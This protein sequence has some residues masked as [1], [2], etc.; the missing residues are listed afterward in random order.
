MD[1]CQ[2]LCF[3]FGEPGRGRGS[4]VATLR[5]I[6]AVSKP[7]NK[8]IPRGSYPSNVEAR[9]RWI[10]RE[11]ESWQ[12]GYDD[13]ERVPSVTAKGGWIH[14][15]FNYLIKLL[16]RSWPSMGEDHRQ[17]IF[18]SRLDTDEVDAKPIQ[19]G[20]ELRET[21]EHSLASPPVVFGTPVLHQCREITELRP[22]RGVVDCLFL[23]ISCIAQ[24]LF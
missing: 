16:D 2:S 3:G 17:R 9:F 19:L 23:W 14:Q 8:N 21:V 1:G 22:L 13:V 4:P 5:N 6:T 20:S 11:T 7:I 15:R 24:P 18:V 12:R 10:V